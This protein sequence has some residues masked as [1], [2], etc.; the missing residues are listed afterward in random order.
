MGDYIV[1]A[2]VVWFLWDITWIAMSLSRIA[3]SFGAT[4]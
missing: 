4:A 1:V 2:G 3:S